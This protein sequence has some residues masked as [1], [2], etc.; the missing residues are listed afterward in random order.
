MGLINAEL[1][2]AVQV[3]SGRL[4]DGRADPTRNTVT[5]IPDDTGPAFVVISIEDLIADR[6]GQDVAHHP[7]GRPEMRAQ[8]VRLFQLAPG[9]DR[10]YLDKRIREE[11][12]NGCSLADLEHFD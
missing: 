4:M 3:V 6:L 2:M 10:D 9:L 11:T 5:R 1:G 7:K 12:L 8:A